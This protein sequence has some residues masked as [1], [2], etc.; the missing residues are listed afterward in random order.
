MTLRARHRKHRAMVDCPFSQAPSSP[1]AS[2]EVQILPLDRDRP[3]SVTPS[4]V[5]RR[6]DFTLNAIQSSPVAALPI[7]MIRRILEHAPE[8]VSIHCSPQIF[9]LGLSSPRR[10]I[11]RNPTQF[12][13]QA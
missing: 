11:G 8:I 5:P 1:A 4:P 7:I 3:T 10:L 9:G 13:L 12:E 6:S 2:S